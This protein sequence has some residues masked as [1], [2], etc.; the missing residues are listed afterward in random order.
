MRFLLVAFFTIFALCLGSMSSPVANAQ[1]DAKWVKY[2]SWKGQVDDLIIF[3]IDKETFKA[4]YPVGS[5]YKNATTE[6]FA[7]D[8]SKECVAKVEVSKGRGDV[9]LVKQ[10]WQRPDDSLRVQVI[11][12]Q[13][14]YGEYEFT[15]YYMEIVLT[16]KEKAKYKKKV[17]QAIFKSDIHLMNIS[18]A[19]DNLM[20][21][22]RW[23]RSAYKIDPL[24]WDVL[25]IIGDLHVK[26]NNE[27]NAVDIF[28]ILRDY[29][30]L[31]D[32][33][34]KLF[35]EL[36]PYEAAKK[37]DDDEDEDE[38]DEDDEGDDDDDDDDEGDD[39]DDDE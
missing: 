36:S 22:L 32:E 19:N 39:D 37:P 33:N 1:D 27:E 34:Q 26:L 18:F 8:P 3:S 14:G 15:I 29:G 5:G 7:S 24:N 6:F 11:D 28:I 16:G 30:H 13:P 38:D 2:V 4:I 35:E 17:D 21:A 9:G 12:D 20:E 23:A 25:N 31:T 10:W